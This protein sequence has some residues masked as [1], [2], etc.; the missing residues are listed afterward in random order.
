[1][2]SLFWCDCSAF[3]LGHLQFSATCHAA[4]Y[5]S[6]VPHLAD[7]G[8]LTYSC[9]GGLAW[10]WGVSWYRCPVTPLGFLPCARTAPPSPA[11]PSG[12][13]TLDG[14][15]SMS[16]SSLLVYSWGWVGGVFAAPLGFLPCAVLFLRACRFPW[17]FQVTGCLSFCFPGD[18]GWAS[19]LPFFFCASPAPLACRGR[20]GYAPCVRVL[21]LRWC[22]LGLKV[23]SPCCPS[24]TLGWVCFWPAVSQAFVGC[25]GSLCCPSWFVAALGSWTAYSGHWMVQVPAVFLNLTL[26]SSLSLPVLAAGL[27]GLRFILGCPP[28]VASL[29]R[30]LTWFFLGYWLACPRG[31]AVPLDSWDRSPISGPSVFFLSP[32]P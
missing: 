26:G 19:A 31:A 15:V 9:S 13:C 3:F 21:Q 2:L 5:P 7:S 12:F 11:S 8:W 18:V 4:G 32:R 23:R 10:G 24:L 17:G 27:R 16:D 6:G 1:M 22:L 14:C 20:R 28:S 29:W 30:G 25:E